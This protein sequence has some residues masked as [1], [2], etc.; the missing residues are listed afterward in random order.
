MQTMSSQHNEKIEP[1][2]G[3]NPSD[4][5]WIRGVNLGGWLVLERYITPYLFAINECDTKGDFHYYEGQVDAPPTS[6]PDYKL[7]DGAAREKCKNIIP[8]PPDEWDLTSAFKDKGIAKKYLDIHYDNFVKKEDIITLKKQGITHLRVPLPHFILGDISEEEPFVEGGWNYFLRLLSWCRELG[9]EAWPDLHTAP[10]S[11]N[12]FDNSGHLVRDGPFTCEGWDS[13]NPLNP[14]EGAVVIDGFDVPALPHNMHRTLRIIDSITSEITKAGFADIV[15]GFGV[16]NE[17]WPNCKNDLMRKFYMTAMKIVRKNML[18]NTGIYFGDMFEAS[19][20]NGFY[21]EDFFGDLGPENMYVDTHIYQSFEAVTRHLSP[22]QHIALV[23]QRNHRD[24][25][26]CCYGN[27]KT[28]VGRVFSEWSASFDQLVAYEMPIYMDQIGWNGVAPGMDRE[29]SPQRQEFLKNFVEAQMV[30]FEAYGEGFKQGRKSS[31]WMSAGWFFWNFKME[32]GEFAEW[33]F[34]RGIRDGW[35]PELPAPTTPSQDVFGNCHDIL[36][37]TKDDMSVMEEYP[38]YDEAN[39]N[40]YPPNDDVILSHGSNMVK[41]HNG[42]WYIKGEYNNEGHFRNAMIFVFVLVVSS[43]LYFV[44]SLRNVSESGS[45][46]GAGYE[47]IDDIEKVKYG[48]RHTFVAGSSSEG[49]PSEE[50]PS[51][52]SYLDA[53]TELVA[54]GH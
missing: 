44:K 46:T 43:I 51:V 54:D 33:D 37:Q 20:F 21:N 9:L 40:G 36:A 45:K 10:G 22:K 18:P 1:R 17:P 6:S 14:Q 39:A 26:G 3:H 41:D 7:M 34:L 25:V 49:S 53:G 32:G 11:Q 29:I 24:A 16:L 12:G 2:F 15:T 23:C 31:D 5:S 28:E 19:R 47:P 13:V 8:F 50:S 48:S 42:N 30:S 35:V 52:D 27:G 38:Y 4:E